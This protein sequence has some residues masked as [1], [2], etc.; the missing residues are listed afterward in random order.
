MSAPEWFR[1]ALVYSATVETFM[2]ANGDGIGDFPGLRS[3]LDH[4]ESLGVDV[5]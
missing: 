4:L 5:V 2:D 3:L 1:N